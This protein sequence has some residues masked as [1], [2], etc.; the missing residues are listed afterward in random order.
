MEDDGSLRSPGLLV[1][2]L[3][4]IGVDDAVVADRLAAGRRVE[5]FAEFVDNVLWV[6]RARA[7]RL[8]LVFGEAGEAAGLAAAVPLGG[9]GR[10]ER[11][12]GAGRHTAQLVRP[13]GTHRHV[14]RRPEVGERPV[15]EPERAVQH[16]FT[17]FG[18][19]LLL[20]AALLGVWFAGVLRVA[21]QRHVGI[22]VPRAHLARVGEHVR[23]LVCQ[24]PAAALGRIHR[25][26]AARERAVE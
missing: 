5:R 8:A 15:V 7:V 16:V 9:P 21:V 14:R 19:H 17:V 3:G 25:R 20:E 11:H 22:P 13:A 4:H 23:R 12:P 26:Q 10:K 24:N 18:S 6:G 1:K 2:G